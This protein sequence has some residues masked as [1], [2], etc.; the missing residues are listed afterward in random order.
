MVVVSLLIISLPLLS[1]LSFASLLSSI[2]SP[3]SLSL[4][5]IIYIINCINII[6]TSLCSGTDAPPHQVVVNMATVDG[7][8]EAADRVARYVLSLFTI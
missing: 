3:L 5:L 6:I 8:K 7:M 2:S 1:L 4:F